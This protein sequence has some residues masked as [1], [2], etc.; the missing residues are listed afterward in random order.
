MTESGKAKILLV[1]DNRDFLKVMESILRD[2]GGYQVVS[3]EDATRTLETV[4]AEQPDV[5]VLDIYMPAVNGPQ[6]CQQLKASPDLRHIPVLFL[7]AVGSD[8]RF[9]ARCLEGGGDDFLEK[10]VGSEELIARIRVLLR[11][12][13]LQ[14]ELRRE[15]DDLERKVQ[16]RAR[17][18]KRRE[19]LAAIGQMV[20]GVAHEIRNPLGAISNSAAVLSRD[21]VLE[22]EDRKLME[23]I[24]READRLKKTI[25][26]FLTFAHP[27]PC[28]FAP[29]D[30]ARLV[31]EVLF[32]ARRDSLCGPEVQFEVQ[33]APDLPPVPADRDRLHQVL[34]NLVRNSLEALKGRGRITLEVRPQAQQGSGGVRIRVADDGPGI[35]E[36]DRELVFEPFFTRKARG[37]GLGLALVHAAVKAHGGRIR[38]CEDLPAGCCFEIWLPLHPDQPS[39]GRA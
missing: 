32:L 15:R 11:I 12:K 37:S 24:V 33:V 2:L 19:S 7:T 13:M 21:L 28:C 9:R 36:A 17:E 3:L 39:G 1:D 4:R 27:P 18:L 20:A 16:E 29:A 6:V 38:L 25:N 5:I 26:E 14:D 22:G 23:I 30:L 35:P 34:W 8:A 31:D 10:P